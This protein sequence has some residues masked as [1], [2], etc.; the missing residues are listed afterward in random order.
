MMMDDEEV[1]RDMAVVVTDIMTIGDN[2]NVRGYVVE[3]S[4]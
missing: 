4:V 3:G 1:H 2:P